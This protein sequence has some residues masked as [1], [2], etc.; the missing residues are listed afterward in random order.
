M[1][2]RKRGKPFSAGAERTFLSW[3]KSSYTA[4]FVRT[5]ETINNILGHWYYD[6]MYL[7]AYNRLLLV[8][9][10]PGDTSRSHAV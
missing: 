4:S 6:V 1:R 5:Q 2:L 3:E 9:R 8:P 10:I 7:G